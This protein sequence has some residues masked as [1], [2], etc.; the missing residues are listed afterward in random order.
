MFELCESLAASVPAP[1]DLAAVQR[2]H[3]ADVSPL[4]VVLLQEIGRY[5][6]LLA[7]IH[8]SLASLRQGIRGLVVISAELERVFDALFTARTRS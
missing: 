7:C 5:N 4:K 6:T 1:L 8:R 2:R 3:E